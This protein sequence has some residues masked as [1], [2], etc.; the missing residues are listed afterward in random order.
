MTLAIE[1]SATWTIST[2]GFRGTLVTI[3]AS[4]TN[5]D[6]AHFDVV[7]FDKNREEER[8]RARPDA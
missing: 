6:L 3:E 2:I 5:G 7:A 4:R 8:R 1:P